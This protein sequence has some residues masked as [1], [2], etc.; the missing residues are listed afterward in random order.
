LVYASRYDGK[1]PQYLAIKAQ[2]RA[3][4]R[5]E[6]LDL[7]NHRRIAAGNPIWLDK[8]EETIE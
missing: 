8:N 3:F 1:E 6:V 7:V 5:V 4:Y 2:K